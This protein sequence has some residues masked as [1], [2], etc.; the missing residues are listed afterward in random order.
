VVEPKLGFSLAFPGP[1]SGAEA[2]MPKK[3]NPFSQVTWHR[4]QMKLLLRS[5]TSLG[6]E[7]NLIYS[8]PPESQLRI[9]LANCEMC[10]DSFS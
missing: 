9:K 2:K 7:G 8:T 10:F 6:M 5:Y 3:P 1:R 4:Q